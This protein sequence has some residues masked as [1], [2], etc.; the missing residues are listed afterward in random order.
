VL[1]RKPRVSKEK[2]GTGE[3][4][5][6]RGRPTKARENDVEEVKIGVIPR[7]SSVEDAVKLLERKREEREAVGT[8]QGGLFD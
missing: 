1:E 3:T 5:K 6:A 4:A 8:V 7:A 2:A